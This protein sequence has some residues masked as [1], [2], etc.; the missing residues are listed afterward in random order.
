MILEHEPVQA[1]PYRPPGQEKRRTRPKP[2]RLRGVGIVLLLTLAVIGGFHIVER[3]HLVRFETLPATAT[4]GIET[5]HVTLGDRALLW[6]G[7][8]AATVKA[9]GHR[10]LRVEFRAHPDSP[11]VVRVELEPLPGKLRVSVQPGVAGEVWLDGKRAGTTGETVGDLSP[12][13]HALQ[14][15]AQGFETHRQTVEVEG[16]GRQT[17]IEI[18]LREAVPEEAAG[19]DSLMITSTPP[20]AD[21]LIDGLFRGRTPKQIQ[22]SP[23]SQAEVALL[24]PGHRPHRQVLTLRPGA[25]SHGATLTPRTGI[26]ELWP[27]PANAK[28]LVDGNVTL[29]RQLHL[30]QR[31]HEIEVSAPGYV[32]GT[33]EILPHP[34]APMQLFAVLQ[35]KAQA[36]QTRRRKYERDLDLTF[37]SFRPRESFEIAT[38]RRRIPV[39]LTRPF[40]I[41]DQEVGNALYLRYRAGHDSGQALGK[42]LNRPSQPVVRL[43][44]TEAALFANWLSEQAGIS[45]F[46]RVRDGQVGGFDANSIGYRLPS[47]AEWVWLTRSAKRYPWG[48]FLPPPDRFANLAD[49]SASDVVKPVLE[50]YDDGHAVSA[51]IGSFAPS[52][53]GLY[54]LPGNVA[55]WVHDV[56][57]DKLQISSREEAERVNPLGEAQGRHYVI[58][59]F[60][61]RDAKRKDL[62]LANRRYG[63]ESRDDVGFRLAYYL[64]AP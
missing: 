4:V 32:T 64:H 63:R 22:T 45:P 36:A 47:E 10:P 20:G 60:G 40:A 9:E 55:E 41:M 50:G 21:I 3:T 30:P 7:Q 25:Q 56:F 46:Y 29:Q 27:H 1:R 39:R 59:G 35:S 58:R 13:S 43:S 11:R 42:R 62:S 28:I 48:D 19:L 6:Q 49:A 52:A 23:G 12:G 17:D 24:L 54:D 53:R 61:W 2:P 38:T 18:A 57:L 8:H 16:F 31:A 14:V 5:P 37:V 51:D 15:R 26:V 44:W 33:Y 34:D